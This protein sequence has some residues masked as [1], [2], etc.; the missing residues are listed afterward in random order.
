VG[1]SRFGS[2]PKLGFRLGTTPT[3]PLKRRGL[4]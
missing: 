2:M 3:P 1:K 4:L